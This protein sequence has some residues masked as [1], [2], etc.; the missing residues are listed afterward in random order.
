M[1]FWHQRR[2]REAIKIKA[3]F[4]NNIWS[5]LL[6]PTLPAAAHHNT[7]ILKRT[8]TSSQQ[9]TRTLHWTRTASILPTQMSFPQA[10]LYISSTT[11]SRPANVKTK[12]A[13][14]RANTPSKEIL[15]MVVVASLVF[16]FKDTLKRV[17]TCS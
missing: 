9:P 11:T 2:V 1:K 4:I 3:L 10:I 8:H 17:L 6:I 13:L 7:D 5:P 12:L 15:L 16:L 14:F